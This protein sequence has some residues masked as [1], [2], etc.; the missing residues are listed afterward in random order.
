MKSL[1]PSVEYLKFLP[2]TLVIHKNFNKQ[3]KLD[4]NWVD[5]VYT[6]VSAF[7]NNTYLIADVKTGRL[8]KRRLNGTHLRKYFD[9]DDNRNVPVV[10]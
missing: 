9:R 6:V 7:S 10:E 4:A 8:L 1:S 3:D 2:G 5:R